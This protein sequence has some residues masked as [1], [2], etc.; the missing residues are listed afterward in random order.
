MDCVQLG[1]ERA[2]GLAQGAV[3]GVDGAVAVGGG[4]EHLTGHLDLDCGLGKK[5][6]TAAL[7]DQDGVVA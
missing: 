2:E 3:Q 5:L 1:V 4:V 7:L 6:G